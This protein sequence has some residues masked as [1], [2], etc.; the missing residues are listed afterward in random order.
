MLNLNG[1]AIESAFMNKT[2][3]C[4]TCL[5]KMA[6]THLVE[7]CPKILTMLL[8]N[9]NRH[10]TTLNP[11]VSFH[12]QRCKLFYIQ[13]QT[14]PSINNARSGHFGSVLSRNMVSM[15]RRNSYNT[16]RTYSGKLFRLF[17]SRSRK[18]TS[19]SV[20]NLP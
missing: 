1:E 4:T 16:Q 3:T 14:G 19:H 17:H 7:S 15:Q 6:V 8:I 9:A 18:S 10:S 11:I 12:G 13:H 2:T 5:Q 20:A